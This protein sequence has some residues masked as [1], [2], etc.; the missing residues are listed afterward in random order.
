MVK[1]LYLIRPLLS[2]VPDIKR[3]DGPIAFREKALW[4]VATLLIFLVCCQIP[5]Y[6]ISHAQ[7]AD[8]LY[9]VRVIMAS[10]RGTLMELGISPIVT[11]SL[12]FQLLAGSKLIS[13][14]YSN[15]EERMLFGAAQKFFGLLITFGQAFAY[16]SSGMYGDVAT[17]GYANALLIVIQLTLAGV[18][19][20]LL[21]EML[22]KGYGIGS[23]ISLFITTSI[24]E[25]ILWKAFSPTTMDTGKGTEFEGA[26]IALFHLLLTRPNKFAAL[27]EAFFRSNLPNLTNLLATL[28][29]FVVVIYFQGFHVTLTAR[30]VKYRNIS[31]PYKIKLFYT[32]NIPIIL[33]TAL[34]SNLYFFS[35][36]LFRRFPTNFLVNLLGQ[37]QYKEGGQAVPVSGLAYFLSPPQSLGEAVTAPFHTAIYF[38]FILFACAL[39][40][41]TW[42]EVSGT[43]PRDVAKQLSDNG[44]VIQGFRRNMSIEYLNRYIP[45]AAELGGVCIGLLSLFADMMGAIGSGTG[46][47]LAVTNIVSIYEQYAKEQAQS[48]QLF[49]LYGGGN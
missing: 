26:V 33:Q 29:V 27:Y 42:I 24:C 20:L 45:V 39:F 30:Y 7:V 19:V 43:S 14:N 41:K 10:N 16:V 37:W 12:I 40:S 46:I 36:L 44:M 47:L 48:G 9:W 4:T 31:Q 2:F 18:I 15:P 17:I 11:S 5:L 49:N 22:Q 25:T 23:G 34:V 38:A 32:S 6:G 3:P 21:D 1:F 13:V 28:V 35:Q 8:P